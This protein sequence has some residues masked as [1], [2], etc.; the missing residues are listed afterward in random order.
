M[1]S[2]SCAAPVN[3]PRRNSIILIS[4]SGGLC[5][6]LAAHQE[7]QRSARERFHH[8]GKARPACRQGRGS[9]QTARAIEPV[10]RIGRRCE[11]SEAKSPVSPASRC[12]RSEGLW[13]P[14]RLAAWLVA[15]VLN[16]PTGGFVVSCR[17]NTPM[18]LCRHCR[19]LPGIGMSA[20][21]P[22]QQCH[23]YCRPRVTHRIASCVSM[24]C[25]RHVSRARCRRWASC[26]MPSTQTGGM[27]AGRAT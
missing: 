18:R 3:S 14:F 9:G 25:I 1:P 27:P 5:H 19:H 26:P 22:G 11:L 6:G 8:G 4:A 17:A 24:G 12:W 16:R 7:D 20:W 13:V 15:A 10:S 2:L 21:T 23:D